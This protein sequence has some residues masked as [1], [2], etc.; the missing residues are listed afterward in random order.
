MQRP[1]V[2]KVCVARG[3]EMT[4]TRVDRECIHLNFVSATVL[5]TQ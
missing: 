3:I 5:G 1:K 2:G 4:L